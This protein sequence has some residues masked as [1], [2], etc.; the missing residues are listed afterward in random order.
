MAEDHEQSAAAEFI[1]GELHVSG[2]VTTTFHHAQDS[3]MSVQVN[4]VHFKAQP[5]CCTLLE[6]EE[7]E[8]VPCKD[9]ST[10]MTKQAGIKLTLRCS[11]T[12]CAIFRRGQWGATHVVLGGATAGTLLVTPTLEGHQW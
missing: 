5:V 6:E 4:L 11:F 2:I 8:T 10:T 3:E 12:S 9:M 7:K 1:K